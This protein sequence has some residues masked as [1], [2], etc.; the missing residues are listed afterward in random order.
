LVPSAVVLVGAALLAIY[1][2]CH[3]RPFAVVKAVAGMM[4]LGILSAAVTI[5]PYLERFKS[6]R[7][8]AYEIK[9]I[10]P[11][12]APLFVYADS[13]NDFNYY[14][15]KQS[16]PVISSPRQLDA[17][18]GGAGGYVLVKERDLGALPQL[19]REW[20]VASESLGSATWHLIELK[21]DTVSPGASGRQT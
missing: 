14:T 5:F 21:R 2:I 13:M 4:A 16:I 7:A 19:S 10:V 8:F 20:I 9:K 12:T 18:V 11:P 1:F 3:R 6:H 15:G 17:L